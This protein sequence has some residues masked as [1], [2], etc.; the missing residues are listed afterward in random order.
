MFKQGKEKKAAGKGKESECKDRPD[1]YELK[2]TE[3][4][5]TD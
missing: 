1:L 4:Q 2:E 3:P 5:M